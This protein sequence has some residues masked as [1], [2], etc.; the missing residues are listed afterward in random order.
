[1]KLI[2]KSEQNYKT[3]IENYAEE[4]ECSVG[5]IDNFLQIDFENGAIKLYSNK[6][7]YEKGAN[8]IIIEPDK[9]NECDYVTEYGT[10]V[11]DIKGCSLEKYLKS[12]DELFKLLNEKESAIIARASYEILIKGIESYENQIQIEITN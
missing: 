7:I 12:T 2:I 3:H 1:M 4:F 8:K 11:L 9:I 5:K 6:L 10:F